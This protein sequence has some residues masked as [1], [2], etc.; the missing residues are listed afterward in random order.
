MKTSRL[1]GPDQTLSGGRFFHF[2]CISLHED[3][4]S[5]QPNIEKANANYLNQL[6]IKM[7]ENTQLLG[8]NYY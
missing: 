7:S 4:Y 3:L 1:T 6:I 2:S 5:A 8:Y